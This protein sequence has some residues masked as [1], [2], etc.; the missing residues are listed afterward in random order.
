MYEFILPALK[1]KEIDTLVLEVI[2]KNIQAIKS[3]ERVG[4]TQVRGLNCYKGNLVKLPINEKLEIKK[5]ENYDWH[6]MQ[7]FW[8]FTPTVQNGILAINELK[9]T[10]VLLGAFLNNQMIGYLIYNPATKRL[11]QIA[12]HKEFRRKGVATSLIQYLTVNFDPSLVVIN[13]DKRDQPI[14]NFFKKMGLE[15]FLEQIEMNLALGLNE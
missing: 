14:D 15:C 4:Y 9:S 13:V 1:E 11:P 8:D 10:L 12:I 6:K 7:S 5:I 3:Y 2:S